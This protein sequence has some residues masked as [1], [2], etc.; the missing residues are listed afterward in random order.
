MPK[1]QPELFL[2]NILVSIDKINRHVKEL[3][4]NEFISNEA[5][6]AVATR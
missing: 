4:L 5:A 6:F 3:S 1:R 2:I